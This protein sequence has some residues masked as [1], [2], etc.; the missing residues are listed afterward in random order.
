MLTL[1]S[2]PDLQTFFEAVVQEGEEQLLADP[3]R[4][5]A[6]A[7]DFGSEILGDYPSP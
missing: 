5:I 4:L 7:G 3:E 2:P 6:L 1:I